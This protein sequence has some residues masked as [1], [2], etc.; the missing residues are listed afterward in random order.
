MQNYSAGNETWWGLTALQ[1]HFETQPL[2]APLAWYVDKLP[3]IVLQLGVLFTLFV[4]IIVP[5]C[6]FLTRRWRMIG[7]G[8][9]VGFQVLVILTGN[10]GVFNLLSILLA[11]PVLV[12]EQLAW[13][14]GRLWEYGPEWP[15]FDGIP[16]IAPGWIQSLVVVVLLFF[17]V[18]VLSG[19]FQVNLIPD[20]I[21]PVWSKV[22]L[23]RTVS[24]YGLFA[25][26]TTRRPEILVQGS[27]RGREWKTYE[28]AYKPDGPGDGPGY[29]APHMPRLDWQMWF[30]ALKPVNRVRWFPPF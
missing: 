12:D 10:Y 7:V 9:I 14:M 18:A 8:L 13:L 19:T 27:R 23:M 29:T 24:S 21:K 4:E 2:P 17:N 6:V 22:R 11:L 16:L 1:Y 3:A 26:M 15:E 20:S 5:F 28:F 30:A 25:D